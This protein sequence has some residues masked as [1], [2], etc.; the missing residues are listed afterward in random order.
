MPTQEQEWNAPVIAEFRANGGQV[1]A[2]Y[3]NPPPMLL[4]H[5]IGARSGL[6]HIVPMRT[7]IEGDAMYVFGSAH[8]GERHPD[9]YRNVIANPDFLVEKGTETFLVHATEVTG[10]ERERVF[11]AHA[12]TF[13]VFADYEQKLE[14]TIPVLKLERR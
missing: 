4:L 14:R 12:A 1:A 6:E 2:P 8:G 11:R 13:P 5:T 10:A 9:W 3:D 7:R